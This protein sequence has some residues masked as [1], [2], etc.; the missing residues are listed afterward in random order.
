MVERIDQVGIFFPN[1]PS[2][3][4]LVCYRRRATPPSARHHL[5]AAQVSRVTMKGCCSPWRGVLVVS[6]HVCCFSKE[7]FPMVRFVWFL[8]FLYGL[9]NLFALVRS[10]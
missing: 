8:V 9:F 6:R 7:P 10:L 2:Q 5:D 4:S 3:S 1:L